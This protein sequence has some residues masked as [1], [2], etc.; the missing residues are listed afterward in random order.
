MAP[1]VGFEPTT[2]R[3][4][5][6][7]ST[8][9]PRSFVAGSDTAVSFKNHRPTDRSITPLFNVSTVTLRRFLRL[10]LSLNLLPYRFLQP[11]TQG[12][13]DCDTRDAGLVQHFNV[14]ADA[15]STSGHVLS[16]TCVTCRRQRGTTARLRVGGWSPSSCGPRKAFPLRRT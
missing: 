2:C 3:L 8:A 14:Y 10:V 4:T 16:V 15:R 6:G 13:S 12:L 1:Q 11:L 9:E 7:C 5:A